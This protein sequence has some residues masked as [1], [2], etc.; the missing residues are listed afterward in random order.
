MSPAPDRAS[1]LGWVEPVQ[2]LNAFEAEPYTLLLHGGGPQPWGRK[3]YLCAYP[4]FIVEDADPA[5]GFDR[6]KSGFRPARQPGHPNRP[7]AKPP[8]VAG[9]AI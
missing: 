3:S 6:L 9:R 1:A 7:A 5:R 2:A 8:G 4:D